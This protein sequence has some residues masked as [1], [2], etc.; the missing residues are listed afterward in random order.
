[1]VIDRKVVP[2][3][4]APTEVPDD[5][6]AWNLQFARPGCIRAAG[7]WWQIQEVATSRIRTCHT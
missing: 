3:A 7:Q 5:A 1:M 6:V 2:A 4:N